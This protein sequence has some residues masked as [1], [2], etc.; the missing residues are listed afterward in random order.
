M[1]DLVLLHHNEPMTTSETVAAGVEMEHK[2]VLQ[3]LRKYLDDLNSLGRV[4]FE[5]RPFE[6]AGGN[7]WREIAFLN[8]GQAMFLMTLM[9]NTEKVVA[10]KL[11]LVKAFLELRDRLTAVPP[12][13]T[14][15]TGNLG[16]GADLAVAA[17]RTFRSFLRVAR[18]AGL[19]LPVA[20]R[21]ANAQTVQRTGMDMLAEI[22]LDPDRPP[23]L[24]PDEGVALDPLA[25]ALGAWAASAEADRYY[26]IEAIVC[27]ATGLPPGHKKLHRHLGKAGPMLRRL[28]F[29][30]ERV[31]ASG[32]AALWI[33]EQT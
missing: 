9:R 24:H 10:F 16:H 15:E 26:S 29:R 13:P 14:F 7:Q 5:M 28:G 27:E 17:D 19:A 32:G 21:V 3:L 2:S 12:A 31:R 11:A 25:E 18:S 22:G 33:K 23:P 20:L 1:S 30:R 8:E 6:T 4:A